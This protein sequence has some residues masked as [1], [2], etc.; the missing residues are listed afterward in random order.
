[1]QIDRLEPGDELD[2]LVLHHVFDWKRGISAF[3]EAPYR[4]GDRG[5]SQLWPV[6]AEVAFAWRVLEYARQAG[7]T[8]EIHASPDVPHGWRIRLAQPPGLAVEGHGASV[9]L[10]ICR[11]ALHAVKAGLLVKSSRLVRRDAPEGGP[12]H[13]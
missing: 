9:S 12:A 1:M 8:I 6:S 5:H 7:L 10:A 13:P 3:G 11:A 2:W 4:C